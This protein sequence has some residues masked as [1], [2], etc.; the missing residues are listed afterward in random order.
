MKPSEFLMDEMALHAV[1]ERVKDDS[2]VMTDVL[3]NC[4][5]V[6]EILVTQSPPHQTVGRDGTLLKRMLMK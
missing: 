6:T 1:T 4:Q 2:H 3:G 5:S